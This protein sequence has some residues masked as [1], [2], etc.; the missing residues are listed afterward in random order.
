MNGFFRCFLFITEF[1]IKKIF[2]DNK[3]KF[4]KGIISFLLKYFIRIITLIKLLSVLLMI[5]IKK[6]IKYHIFSFHG[7]FQIDRSIKGL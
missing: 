2:L 7:L 6:V 1:F 5:T 3:I 4:N